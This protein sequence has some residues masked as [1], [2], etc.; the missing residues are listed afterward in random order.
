MCLKKKI[1]PFSYF[2]QA[3]AFGGQR[4]PG[5][6]TS[7]TS[8]G[9]AVGPHSCPQPLFGLGCLGA[10]G[11]SALWKVGCLALMAQDLKGRFSSPISLCWVTSICPCKQHTLPCMTPPCFYTEGSKQ[12]EGYIFL[13]TPVTAD[14][15]LAVTL[16]S[17][18]G[19][20]SIVQTSLRAFVT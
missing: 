11:V 2:C 17:C 4:V 16:L 15:A 12:G 6:R 14:V 7:V 20:V 3:S 10:T 18:C 9:R 8:L 1:T 19:Q 13:S 5:N